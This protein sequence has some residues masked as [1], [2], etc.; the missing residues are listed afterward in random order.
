M[1]VAVVG[2]GVVGLSTTAELLRRGVD[3]VCHERAGGPMAQRSAGSSRIFRLAHPTPDLVRLAQAAREGFGRWEQASHTAMIAPGGCVIS[4][5]Q[6]SGWAAAMAAAGAAHEIVDGRSGRLRLPARRPPSAALVDPSGGVIDVDAVRA[7]L[8]EVT[9]GAVVQNHVYALED[10]PTGA[11]VW[12]SAGTA[13]F[14][15]VLLTAGAGTSPLAAQVGIYTP[16]ALAH[17][18]RFTFPVDPAVSWQCWIDKPS[19]GLATYQHRSGPG[20]WAV[21]GSIDPGQV[22]WEAGRDAATA[23]S[24]D[25]V[26]RYAREHLA[27][28]P[29]VVDTLY[30]VTTPGLADG[31]EFRRHGA[32]LAVSGENLFKFAPL[33]GEVLAEACTGG[34]T[35]AVADLARR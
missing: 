33:L 20:R 19:A 32:I 3:V 26:L 14:D 16:P 2:A 8:I 29:R 24:R 23:A 17:H 28:E 11:T 15:A 12:S 31:F 27:V 13:R 34:S 4:G 1:R 10:T 21:G 25:A 22:A 18:V 7:H 6:V 35:P 9:S 5:D 30:C